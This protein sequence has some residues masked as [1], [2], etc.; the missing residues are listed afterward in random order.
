MP[1]VQGNLTAV[2]WQKIDVGNASTNHGIYAGHDAREPTERDKPGRTTHKFLYTR[3][4][5]QVF[6]LFHLKVL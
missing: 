2:F 3:K 6:F 4:V 1:A 5:V